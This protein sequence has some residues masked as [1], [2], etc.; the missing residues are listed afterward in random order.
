MLHSFCNADDAGFR[1]TVTWHD[2]LLK[3]LE[4]GTAL[5][6]YQLG[7]LLDDTRFNSQQVQDIFLFFI[8]SRPVLG[9]T[10]HHKQ[11]HRQF[12]QG[13]NWPGQ[14][15]TAH[16]HLLPRLKMTAAI[17][18]LP[19]CAFMVCRTGTLTLYFSLSITASLINSDNFSTSFVPPDLPLKHCNLQQF[20]CAF[21][22]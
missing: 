18:L 7:Y 13:Q 20:S 11:W 4:V 16:L 3:A 6:I 15:L 12:S 8:K 19:V 22:L 10:K 21:E 1:E 17:P 2:I 5:S 14:K 9:P